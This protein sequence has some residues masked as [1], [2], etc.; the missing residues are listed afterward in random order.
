MI[1]YPIP[2]KRE[3]LVPNS[4]CLEYQHSY[5]VTETSL[6][7]HSPLVDAYEKI[8]NLSPP[9]QPSLSGKYSVKYF[10]TF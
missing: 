1:M 2:Y 7:V 8:R 6:V 3:S 10:E 9:V 4:V 5:R